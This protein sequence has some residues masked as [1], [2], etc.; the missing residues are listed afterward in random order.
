MICASVWERLTGST[1]SSVPSTPREALQPPTAVYAKCPWNHS[2][3]GGKQNTAL[4]RMSPPDPRCPTTSSSS[5]CSLD[6]AGPAPSPGW[7]GELLVEGCCRQLP[8]LPLGVG[9]AARLEAEE[10]HSAEGRRVGDILLSSLSLSL[11][12]P[13]SA[14]CYAA[15]NND[16]NNESQ[17]SSISSCDRRGMVGGWGVAI[18]G[19]PSVAPSVRS[20]R[21]N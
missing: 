16:T 2:T 17:F 21:V 11:F 20:L 9:A 6:P 7:C 10:I 1:G 18:L 14:V 15:P 5:W 13:P 8:L 19:I 3:P 12:L 4:P